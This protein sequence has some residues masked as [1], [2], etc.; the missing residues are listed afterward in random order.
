MCSGDGTRITFCAVQHIKYFDGVTLIRALS[1]VF[2]SYKPRRH[3]GSFLTGGGG[4]C[5]RCLCTVTSSPVLEFPS[6]AQPRTPSCY[7]HL[8]QNSFQWLP[9]PTPEDLP[10]L[11]RE[12]GKSCG[13]A[14]RCLLSC[15]LSLPAGYLLDY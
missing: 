1:S 11:R 14:G 8:V 10:F 13:T 15:R 5:I 6:T 4:H 9:A 3:R 7:R 2:P 12:R